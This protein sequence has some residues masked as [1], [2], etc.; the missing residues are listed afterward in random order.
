MKRFF[1]EKK[2]ILLQ[3]SAAMLSILKSL[4]LLPHGDRIQSIKEETKRNE[5]DEVPQFFILRPQR[6]AR[7]LAGEY[8]SYIRVRM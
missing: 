2:D 4:S 8:D 7:D 6:S 5:Q 3:I 1:Q